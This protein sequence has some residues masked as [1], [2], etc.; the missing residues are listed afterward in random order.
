MPRK[1]RRGWPPQPKNN[2]TDEEG[3]VRG[4]PHR[5]VLNMVCVRNEFFVSQMTM[6]QMWIVSE[7]VHW[8]FKSSLKFFRT[9]SLKIQETI[10][11]HVFKIL[12]TSLKMISWTSGS[13]L[14]SSP[15]SLQQKMI[16]SWTESFHNN[17]IIKQTRPWFPECWFL[18][19]CG[20]PIP[21]F[22]CMWSTV[23][24]A[25]SNQCT[26]QPT[27]DQKNVFQMKMSINCVFQFTATASA[28]Q[29]SKCVVQPKAF[30]CR[31]HVC[32]WF[33]EQALLSVMGP[34]AT[35]QPQC[36]LLVENVAQKN[37]EHIITNH[38]RLIAC[39]T[40]WLH[41]QPLHNTWKTFALFG[42]MWAVGVNDGHQQSQ[43]K[44]VD[45]SRR[46]IVYVSGESVT[47]RN[48]S[49]LTDCNSSH[50]D[51][52]WSN[53]CY[54]TGLVHAPTLTLSHC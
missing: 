47:P 33:T 18:S 39:V 38:M 8:I 34:V 30:A 1:W 11:R 17:T 37:N 22:H 6:S 7:T 42:A 29:C 49:T 19:L 46:S 2:P 21:I 9:E 25:H 51:R 45:S 5:K 36:S 28:P 15:V 14:E 32:D 53:S 52:L 3:N 10:C 26:L 40:Q 24:W 43:Q 16:I 50:L 27:C 13:S 35:A 48:L 4:P 20:F 54:W 44:H 23:H 12:K 31:T 41:D